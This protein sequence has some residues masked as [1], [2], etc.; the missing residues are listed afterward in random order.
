MARLVDRAANRAVVES[1]S[2][3]RDPLLLEVDLDA[4]DSA[5]AAVDAQAQPPI[6][7]FWGSRY[8]VVVDPDGNRIGLKSPVD[9]AFR[10]RPPDL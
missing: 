4:G 2:D 6:D 1:R 10:S 5:E 8:A 9:P 3:N 7:A